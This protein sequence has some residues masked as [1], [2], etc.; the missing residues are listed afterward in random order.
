MSQ[1]RPCAASGKQAFGTGYILRNAGEPW[2]IATRG[3]PRTTKAIRS[4]IIAPTREHSRKPEAA[5]AA[6]ERLMPEVQRLD[7]FSRQRRPGWTSW[8]NE[9]DRF[10]EVA[11]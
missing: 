1:N 8:G 6:A 10:S 9:V 7:L 2:M 11:N 5:Y 4:V 3:A